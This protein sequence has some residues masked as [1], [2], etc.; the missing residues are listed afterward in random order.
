MA[1]SQ[2]TRHS[3]ERLGDNAHVLGRSGRGI[4]RLKLTASS[5]GRHDE[6]PPSREVAVVPA[7]AGGVASSSKHPRSR[8]L[9]R[10]SANRC[11]AL[12]GV[13]ETADERADLVPVEEGVSLPAGYYERVV[14][15]GIDLAEGRISPD[16]QPA[17]AGH[18]GGV[19]RA[20]VDM[21]FFSCRV[22]KP[23]R[24][25]SNSA[26]PSYIKTGTFM[27]STPREMHV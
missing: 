23:N 10:C 8:K 7:Q 18:P 24:V 14:L 21:T 25:I 22:M 27:G 19:V 6:G 16:C 15:I 12:A 1:A 11:N 9:H 5:H 2:H 20:T 13:V 17:G 4:V 3:A 26:N